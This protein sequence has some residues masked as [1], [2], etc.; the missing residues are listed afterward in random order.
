MN[1][2]SPGVTDSDCQKLQTMVRSEERRKLSS[3]TSARVLGHIHNTTAC[4]TMRVEIFPPES[5][6]EPR[7]WMRHDQTFAMM[8]GRGSNEWGS[9]RSAME[10]FDYAAGDLALCDRHVGE[11]VGVPGC[12]LVR[13]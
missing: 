2:L 8:L 4:K 1:T 5:V 13:C 9:R 6:T 12:F 11:W 10:E 3:P 7:N